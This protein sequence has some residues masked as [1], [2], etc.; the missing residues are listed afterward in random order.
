MSKEK[1]LGSYTA[2]SHMCR[3]MLLK[4][5]RVEPYSMPP[6]Q[7]TS[8]LSGPGKSSALPTEHIRNSAEWRWI[9]LETLI[10]LCWSF[11]PC[12]H[13]ARRSRSKWTSRDSSLLPQCKQARPLEC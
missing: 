10:A 3:Y 2:P 6:T 7:P 12:D 5:E 1:A 4:P 8:W 11:H 9:L 13:G